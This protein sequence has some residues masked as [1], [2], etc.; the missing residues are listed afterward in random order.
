MQL[1]A[2][3]TGQAEMGPLEPGTE[4]VEPE[5][6]GDKPMV[7]VAWGSGMGIYYLPPDQLEHYPCF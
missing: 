4:K 2:G 5:V 7:E 3:T 1:R 6:S